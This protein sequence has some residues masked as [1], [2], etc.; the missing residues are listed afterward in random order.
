MLKGQKILVTGS[1]MGN[2]AAVAKGLAQLGAELI[3][4][5]IREDLAISTA[6]E[7]VAAGGHAWPLH[8]DVADP[9]SCA[10]A[11]QTVKDRTGALTVLV[12]NAAILRHGTIDSPDF[13]KDWEEVVK[14][15]LN[16]TLFPIMAFVAQ[17]RET[18]G[19]IVNT[20]SIAAN[21]SLGTFAGY[22]AAKA[23]VLALTRS[24]AK[25]LATDGIRVNAVIPGAFHTPMTDY[26]DEKRN[27]FY[28]NSIPME[29]FGAPSEMTG[30]IAFL[31]SDL[32]SYVTGVSLPVDGGF[33]IS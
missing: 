4:A 26:M 18:R 1:G 20:A 6:A 14:V 17:L 11:A 31:A 30:P 2:G 8:M 15:N 27:D 16:G 29:R 12:N 3:V 19:A 13:L 23:G 32:A 24:L 33:S 5:D 9:S 25:E 7:I 22:G 10:R 21:F 28:M